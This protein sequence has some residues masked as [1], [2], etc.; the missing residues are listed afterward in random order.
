MSITSCSVLSLLNKEIVWYASLFVFQYFRPQEE[1]I[2]VVG[3]TVP[4]D[5]KTKG[6]VIASLKII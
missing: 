3:A 2:S 1:I 5:L 4:V 6:D